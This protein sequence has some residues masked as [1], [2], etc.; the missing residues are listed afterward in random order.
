MENRYTKEAY[1]ITKW[2]RENSLDDDYIFSQNIGDHIKQKL[3]DDFGDI[4]P[5]IALYGGEDMCHH[6]LEYILKFQHQLN[7]ERAFSYTDLILGLIWY[8]K[9]GMYH[10]EA[11][12]LS[13]KLADDVVRN[14]YRGDKI[15]SVSKKGLLLPLTHGVDTTFIEV[16]T[17]LYR[18][19][20][21]QKY[22]DLAISTA[23]FFQSLKDSRADGL[24]PENSTFIF[25]LPTLK[26][27]LRKRFC[28]A[29]I[30]KDNTNYCYGLLDLWRLTKK[31]EIKSSFDETHIAL[32]KLAKIDQLRNSL[33][34]DD[35]ASELLSSFGYIDLSCDAYMLFGDY[36]YLEEVIPFANEW[37]S[38]QSPSTGLMPIKKGQKGSYFDSETDMAIA[39]YKL[40][41]CTG[42]VKYKQATEKIALGILKYHKYQNAFVLSVNI[43]NG[44]I[45]DP[46]VKTK[47][48]ALFI[49]LL[50]LLGE[51][52][53]IY[54]DEKLFML[55]KDR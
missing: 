39:L 51:D 12:E 15:Y 36:R 16:W 2:L 35:S 6:H 25:L 46:F 49:K 20:K 13:Q 42:E 38:Q 19:T 1:R 23:N 5:F 55:M 47:F 41:E 24:I 50:H 3:I 40:Y 29:K 18:S 11:L 44:E 52:S 31:S 48:V 4:A 37:L 8:S 54:S 14:W 26:F 34:T 53:I 45:I 7:F 43:D 28:N 22:L 10:S 32:S 17:E 21:E 9:V 27:F 33:N 30:L